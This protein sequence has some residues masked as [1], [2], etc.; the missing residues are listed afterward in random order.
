MKESTKQGIKNSGVFMIFGTQNYFDDVPMEEI[1]YA[2]SLGKPF[3]VLV[4]KGI[5]VPE[6]LKEGI[7][8]YKEKIM[9]LRRMPDVNHVEIKEFLKV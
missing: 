2:K 3:R 7:K 9:D 8:D 1:N 5:K 4:D 6:N